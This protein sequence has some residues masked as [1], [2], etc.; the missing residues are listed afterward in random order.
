MHMSEWYQGHD[1][2]LTS[3]HHYRTLVLIAP[4][5]TL[6]ETSLALQVMLK[7]IVSKGFFGI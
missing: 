7:G 4:L 3:P 1:E 5:D 2:C 6:G